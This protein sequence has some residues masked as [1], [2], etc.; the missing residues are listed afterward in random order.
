MICDYAG[1][2]ISGL[3]SKNNRLVWGCMM[4]L[5]K[6]AHM[7]YQPIYERLDAIVSA[8][9]SG[10]TI[11]VDNSISVFAG[12]CKGSDEVE[13]IVLPILL[14]H[15]KKCRPKEVAQHAE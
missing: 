3:Y 11:T 2:F 15:L 7:A 12:L 13:N 14:A 5:A 10:S 8:Y 9:E 6:I 4:A 1:D